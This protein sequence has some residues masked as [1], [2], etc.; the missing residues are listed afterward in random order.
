M[1]CLGA[2]DSFILN[3]FTMEAAFQGAA[4]GLLG[5]L[6]GFLVELARGSL[7]WG[8]YLFRYFPAA[9]LGQ[10]ALLSFTVGIGIAIVAAIYPSWA[11]SRML[12]M[13]AMRVD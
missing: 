8:G 2:T 5:T 9:D 6:L 13:D 4:G 7:S 10:V 1:K 12:P 3:M 11:A